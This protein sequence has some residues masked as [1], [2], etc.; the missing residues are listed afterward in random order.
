MNILFDRRRSQPQTATGFL[1]FRNFSFTHTKCLALTLSFVISLLGTTAV[2]SKDILQNQILVKGSTDFRA[3]SLHSWKGTPRLGVPD[4]TG[5]ADAAAGYNMRTVLQ[6]NKELARQ[7][8]ESLERHNY[9]LGLLATLD[10][11]RV[12]ADCFASMN[13]YKA[14]VE[15]CSGT[16]IQ[17]NVQLQPWNAYIK[18]MALALAPAAHGELFCPFTEGKSGCA[19][20]SIEQIRAKGPNGRA[21]TLDEFE[22][23]DFFSKLMKGHQSN[24][25]SL[26]KNS[27]FPPE[28]W[29][30]EVIRLSE[31]D[32]DKQR[33]VFSISP[34]G[35]FINNQFPLVFTAESVKGSGLKSRMLAVAP[36][37]KATNGFEKGVAPGGRQTFEVSLPM[38]PATARALGQSNQSRMFYAVTKLRFLPREQANGSSPLA[39]A[40]KLE[41]YYA[42]N[43]VELYRD[44]S[45]TQKVAERPLKASATTER[46]KNLPKASLQWPKGQRIF[47]DR[48]Y[49]LLRIKQGD[50][51]DKLLQVLTNSVAQGERRIWM[52]YAGRLK[53]LQRETPAAVTEAQQ[54]AAANTRHRAE[55]R[56]KLSHLSWQGMNNAQKNTLYGYMLG[57]GDN[58]NTWPGSFPAVP[59][60][61]NAA[62]IFE[63]D[64]FSIDRTV[65]HLP[66]TEQDKG[67]LQQFLREFAKDYAMDK[68]TLVYDLRDTQYNSQSQVLELRSQSWPF[69]I[70][71]YI[72]FDDDA[73][74]TFTSAASPLVN[75]AAKALAIYP[76]S[77][78]SGSLGNHIPNPA[79]PICQRNKQQNS[80]DCVTAYS[81]FLQVN[82]V[83]ASFALDRTL[84]IPTLKM[85]P[86]QAT[87]LVNS[88]KRG[89]P[90]WRL[91]VELGNVEMKLSPFVYKSSSQKESRKGEAQTVFASVAK[92]YI[93]A[94]ND[95][96]VWQA[97]LETLDKPVDAATL[98]A[99]QTAAYSWPP[100]VELFSKSQPNRVIYDFLFAKYYPQLLDEHFLEAMFSSRWSYEKSAEAPIGGRYFNQ[101]ARKPTWQDIQ[102]SLPRFKQWLTQLAASMPNKLKVLL[103]IQYANDTLIE[104]TQCIKL[105]LTPDS[106]L[107]NNG[108]AKILADQEV[109]QCMSREKQ[110]ASQ[111]DRCETLRAK[112]DA[113]ETALDK[114][115][116]AG[117]Q[118]T[119]ESAPQ[120][121]IQID[122]SGSCDFSNVDFS[123]MQSAMQTCM[124]D[125][126]GST[127]TTMASMATYQACIQ[128]VSTEMQ[129]QMRAALGG[130]RSKP[131][132]QP[133]STVLDNCKPHRYVIRDTKASLTSYRCDTHLAAPTPMD[134]S[135]L[136]KVPRVTHMHVEQL[137]FR[138]NRC[139][140]DASFSRKSNSSAQLLPYARPYSDT[141]LEI[142]IDLGMLKVPYDPPYPANGPSNAVL[143]LDLEIQSIESN[144][145]KTVMTFQTDIKAS[146]ISKR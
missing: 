146:S 46:V 14:Q 102:H 141:H 131:K 24:F 106:P 125:R 55:D 99:E 71:P 134:C 44:S 111:F 12:N 144:P 105:K 130:G 139:G 70:R 124:V 93:L 135:V 84:P 28:A 85:D 98:E 19:A 114:A 4:N 90:G 126:C 87:R 118:Q 61:I 100:S 121:T 17:H 138:D 47:D 39:G 145:R 128:A 137:Q 18:N 104:Q 21:V 68:L 15:R 58:H 95:E 13:K 116:Q 133:Q 40:N 78:S 103:P 22:R 60:G 10:Y 67:V 9:S 123:K 83:N 69:H 107:R 63:K 75:S 43:K 16:L 51:D 30:V 54:E 110:A 97:S 91:V 96:T 143:E 127:P 73:S 79:V 37:Y 5:I 27:H 35:S 86:E 89:G 113:A 122:A 115:E 76:F 92:A 119:V 82:W 23:R 20:T 56:A 41:F 109:R 2:H 42:Q 62:T 112:L 25:D 45:L 53:E 120:N 38:D 48:A 65:A 142:Q 49:A 33:Y 72:T 34:P 101:D 8:G 77:T 11:M 57:E 26:W 7:L 88:Q 66:A 140:G 31:Y 36:K 1:L 29:F 74:Q 3:I 50:L 136:G 80:T 59:W 81:H 64:H 52:D 129:E 32:F 94:P 117:C 108:T 6:K 132:K